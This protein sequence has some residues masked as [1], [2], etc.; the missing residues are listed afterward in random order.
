MTLII[1]CVNPDY[2]II[3]GDTQLTIGDLIRGENLKREIKFKVHQF[4]H[5]LMI[6]ILGKWS[7]YFADNPGPAT[8][9]DHF[10]CLQRVIYRKEDKL[11]FLREYIRPGKGIDGAAIYVDR[12]DNGFELGSISTSENRLLSSLNFSETE[13]LFNEPFYECKNNFVKEKII[14]LY[15]EY[16]L[17]NS[18]G[19]ILFL[20]NNIILELS[21]SGKNIGIKTEEGTLEFPNTVGGYIN[22]QVMTKNIH[23]SNCLFNFYKADP[24][25]LLDKTTF[26]FAKFVDQNPEI[27]Y[28]DN[29][30]MLIRNYNN[31]D[32]DGDIEGG[33][34]FGGCWSLWI[35]PAKITSITYVLAEKVMEKQPEYLVQ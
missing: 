17:N 12:T 21:S 7:W 27:R 33:G 14:K 2:A 1:G 30:S 32:I 31:R 5:K 3:A 34:K 18:F 26:A 23:Y 22:I 11:G 8:Y 10:D 20:I 35:T 13:L 24:N 6:G 9:I 4:S 15:K 19:D 16:E 29:L 28:V 25:T